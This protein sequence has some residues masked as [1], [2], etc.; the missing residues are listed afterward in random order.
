MNTPFKKPFGAQADLGFSPELM[1]RNM[2]DVSPTLKESAGGW[3]GQLSSGVIAAPALHCQVVGNGTRKVIVRNKRKA[4]QEI[5]S[6]QLSFLYNKPCLVIKLEIHGVHV[7]VFLYKLIYKYWS[8]FSW[9]L[10]KKVCKLLLPICRESN[11]YFNYNE[12]PILLHLV[13]CKRS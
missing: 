6:T 8:G 10:F 3:S 2:E 7:H 9:L 12:K 11:Y 5:L 1:E 4:I 13:T